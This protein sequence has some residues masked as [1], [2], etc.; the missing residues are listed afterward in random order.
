MSRDTSAISSVIPFPVPSAAPGPVGERPP[1]KAA[2][3]T[4]DYRLVIEQG[5]RAGSYVYKTI[6]R[7]T[8]ETIK[9]FPRED[10]IKLVGDPRYAAGTITSTR[11]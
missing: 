8:G 10:L 3:G 5:P 4:T 11:A 9:Q 6:D 7:Q 2:S 1:G